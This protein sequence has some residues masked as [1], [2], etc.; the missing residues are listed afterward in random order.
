MSGVI[1]ANDSVGDDDD[2]EE[3]SK[4]GVLGTVEMLRGM[5]KGVTLVRSA[6][7]LKAALSTLPLRVRGI[8]DRGRYLVGTA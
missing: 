3:T 1:R 2:D 8:V 7:L 6:K 4:G 5:V